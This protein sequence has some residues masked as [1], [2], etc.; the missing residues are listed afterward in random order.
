MSTEFAQKVYEALKKV[1]R[2]KVISYKRLAEM[3]GSK[4]YRAVGSVLAKNPYAPV[5]PCHRVV[6]SDGSLGGFMGSKSKNNLIKKQLLLNSEGVI[7]KDGKIVDF[8]VISF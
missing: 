8:E 1:P 3:I 6:A 5:V 2:G 4:A 7:I